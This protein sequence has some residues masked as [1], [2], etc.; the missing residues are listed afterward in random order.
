MAGYDSSLSGQ[1]VVDAVAKVEGLAKGKLE[2]V[3]VT[4]VI[5]G[6]TVTYTIP[7]GVVAFCYQHDDATSVVLNLDC[8]SFPSEEIYQ[9]HIFVDD[10]S[11]ASLSIGWQGATYSTIWWPNGS[12]PTLEGYYHTSLELSLLAGVGYEDAESYFFAYGMWN[13]LSPTHL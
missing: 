5:S 10:I 4:P 6:S 2:T 1:R 13:R 7:A 12:A 9:F 3:D 11:S 8:P